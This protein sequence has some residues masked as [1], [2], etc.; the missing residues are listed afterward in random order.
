M[1]NAFA[2]LT[3][4]SLLILFNEASGQRRKD[5]H[6]EQ[7]DVNKIFIIKNGSEKTLQKQHHDDISLAKEDSLFRSL[8]DKL[9]AGLKEGDGPIM[10]AP[11]L[12]KKLD[13]ALH[14]QE[15]HAIKKI[16]RKSNTSLRKRSYTGSKKYPVSPEL[17]KTIVISRVGDGSKEF[18]GN[19][20]EKLPIVLANGDV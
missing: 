4:I 16:L 7:Q 5:A 3:F 12:K 6:I 14:Q 20:P 10:S 18:L 13:L 11:V 1:P 2:T 17:D 8:E 19:V 9:E 15:A